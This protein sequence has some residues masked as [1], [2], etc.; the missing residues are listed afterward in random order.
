MIQGSDEIELDL[1]QDFDFDL[2]REIITITC[3]QCGQ[4]HVR[5]FYSPYQ[6]RTLRCGC[7]AS[8][9]LNLPGLSQLMA[10]AVRGDRS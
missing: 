1:E 9:N 10:C 5:L 6:G 7:G 4:Q 3:P 8:L 2:E